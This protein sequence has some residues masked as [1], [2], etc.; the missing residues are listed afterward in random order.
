MTQQ[1]N[2]TTPQAGT[3]GTAQ[4][5]IKRF[6]PER[7][8]T[9]NGSA[10]V[11]DVVASRIDITLIGDGGLTR[12]HVYTGATADALIVALNKA[13]LV[14]KS[15]DQRIFERLIADGKEAG[16]IAGTPD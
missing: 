13:D 15:L 1:I 4:W 8:W 5:K 14:A 12:T 11:L 10:L 2:N 16:T 6:F 9:W 7:G 3:A